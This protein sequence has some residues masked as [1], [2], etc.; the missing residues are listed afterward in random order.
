MPSIADNIKAKFQNAA[1]AFTQKREKNPK[2]SKEKRK[3]MENVDYSEK[4]LADDYRKL[5]F[6]VNDIKTKLERLKAA[7]DDIENERY[8]SLKI[9]YERILATAIPSLNSLKELVDSKTLEL[10]EKLTEIARQIE[11]ISGIIRQEDKLYEV[12]AISVD[13]YNL[14]I[15]PLKSTLKKHNVELKKIKTRIES[16][17]GLDN[18]SAMQ[19]GTQLDADI[20]FATFGSRFVAMMT[21]SIILIPLV[22]L[23]FVIPV[24]GGAMSVILGYAYFI[25]LESSEWQA[26]VGKRMMGIIVV[27]DEGDRISPKTALFRL[28]AKSLSSVLFCAGYFLMLFSEKRQCL[29]DYIAGTLVIKAP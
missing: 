20:H 24:I 21:D 29:H 11:V 6:N 3:H 19:R 22:I 8:E 27:D 7:K 12:G 26:T 17:K 10:T 16:L 14:K 28:L 2:T 1:N 25:F 5:H 4:K 23:S 18:G 15:H 13:D 9:E